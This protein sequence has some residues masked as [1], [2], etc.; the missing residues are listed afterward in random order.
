MDGY[1]A[2][3]QAEQIEKLRELFPEAVSEG[4][5]DFT[6]LKATLGDS[7]DIGE[8]YGLNWKGKSNVFAKIQEK[9]TSTFHPQPEESTDWDTTQNMFIEGDNLEALKVLHKAYY[10]KV[11]MIYIDPPY[12][13]GNDFVYNDDFAKTKRQNAM[14]E[15]DIDDEGFA[16]RDDGLR[17]N[18]GGHRHSNWLDMM[19]PRLFL[20]RNLL[21]QDGVIFVSI[22]DNEVHNLRLMMNEIFGE[23]NFVAQIPWRKRTAKSDVPFGFSQDFEWVIAFARSQ[24]FLAGEPVDRRYYKTEDYPND[25]WRLADLTKQTAATE[26]PKSAFDLVNPKTGDIYP[27]NPNR[28]W[29]ITKDTFNDYY[30]RGKIVF[31]GDYDFLKINIPAF[32]VFESEDRKKNMEKYGTEIA[33]KSVSTLL[34]KHTELSEKGNDDIVDLFSR[35]VFSF[36]KPVSLMKRLVSCV[37][38]SD[39]IILD[40]FGGSGT[41]AHAVDEL[42]AEDGGNRKWI[43]VQLPE[44]TDEKSEAY[45]A[46]YKT[47]ADISRER[48]RRAGAK[49]SKD[50]ADKIAERD[51][52][53]DL[54][55]R[56][57]VLG[58]SNFKKWNEL[59]SGSDEIR[60][61]S[62]DQ[63]EPLESSAADDHVL[64][65]ILLK[66]GISPLVDIEEHKGFYF[67]VSEN[68]IVSLS[69]QMTEPLFAQ[70]LVLKP[71]QIIL[72]DQAFSGDVNLKTNL[73]LQAEKQSIS[74]EVL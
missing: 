72:L 50:F 48:I 49:I 21:R 56:S 70:I 23:E 1:N 17:V 26:R 19:Y 39:D 54:G 22:D 52:P 9:T 29:S 38:K 40:F 25:S 6:K 42:N 55:F 46:G 73:I 2:D 31:P 24:T 36:P 66:R 14:D 61:A 64:T 59:V 5:V 30:D 13:T 45:K 67:I 15:G 57:Y 63:I 27:F 68:L 12:N 74:V 41:M 11:K 47:I 33:Q 58:G 35:K 60:Q 18:N 71:T 53:L 43:M 37:S 69:R 34:P 44:L 65:E 62:L 8:K 10:G 32:R 16:T 3:I 7:V 28:T 51:T 20:A 4:K